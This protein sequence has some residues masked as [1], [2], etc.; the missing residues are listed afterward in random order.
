MTSKPK[1]KVGDVVRLKSGGPHLTVAIVNSASCIAMWANEHGPHAITA[2][3]ECFED[4]A[5]SRFAPRNPP[6]GAAA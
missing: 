1:W 3:H 4:P 6:P 2:S 5:A